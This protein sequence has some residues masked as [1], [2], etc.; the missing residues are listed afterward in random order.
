MDCGTS[1]NS[2]ETKKDRLSDYLLDND[3]FHSFVNNFSPLLLCKINGFDIFN[4]VDFFQICWL[5]V[6]V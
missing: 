5:G 6:H 4:I 3:F 2:F 1:M